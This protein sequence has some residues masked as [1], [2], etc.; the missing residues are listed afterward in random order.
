LINEGLVVS[1]PISIGSIVV[2]PPVAV[3]MFAAGLSPQLTRRA[4]TRQAAGVEVMPGRRRHLFM[5]RAPPRGRV[6]VILARAACGRRADLDW[7]DHDLLGICA[8]A[9]FE[10]CA[11]AVPEGAMNR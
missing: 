5:G 8:E 1:G 2:T 11:P 4:Q 6:T 10:Q 9:D 7:T 3:A